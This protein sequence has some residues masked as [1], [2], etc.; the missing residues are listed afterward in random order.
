VSR[1]SEAKRP[2]WQTAVIVLV[3]F[4]IAT[5]VASFYLGST[6]S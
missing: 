5:T 1:V 2:G 3:V 6:S 4:V